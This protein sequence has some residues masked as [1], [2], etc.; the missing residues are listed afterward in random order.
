VDAWFAVY[1][2]AIFTLHDQYIFSPMRGEEPLENVENSTFYKTK[3][4]H[5]ITKSIT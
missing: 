5:C 2:M 4:T 3:H 1:I